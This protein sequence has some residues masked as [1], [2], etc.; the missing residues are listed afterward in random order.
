MIFK[1]NIILFILDLRYI[2]NIEI[3]Y[4][5][6]H[7]RI[8]VYDLYNISNIIRT[9][10][11]HISIHDTKYL[12]FYVRTVCTSCVCVTTNETTLA[13]GESDCD[14]CMLKS[15][16]ILILVCHISVLFVFFHIVVYTLVQFNV[17]LRTYHLASIQNFINL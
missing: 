8:V 5:Y 3:Q 7:I 14:V 11:Y 1:K 10:P 16:I 13:A 17:V 9:N 15:G 12:I 6:Y 2:C 4:I